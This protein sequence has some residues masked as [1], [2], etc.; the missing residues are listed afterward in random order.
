MTEKS[1]TV[2]T[3]TDQDRVY[4]A[5]EGLMGSL[6]DPYSEFFPPKDAKSFEDEI[7]GS[8]DGIGMEVGVKNGV[9]TVIAPLKGTPAEKAGIKTGDVILKIGTTVTTNLNVDDAINMIR[10]PKGTTVTLTI[11]HEGSQQPQTI[12]ITR[13]TIAIPTLDTIA[14]PDGIFVIK[15]YSFDADSATLFS[16]A[17]KQFE[18]SGD[19]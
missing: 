12:S 10:G 11:L 15:L 17:I 6:N 18:H 19:T 8:F 1:L 2:N 4:G 9:L 13:D 16:N 14:R 7:A 5:I 3:I